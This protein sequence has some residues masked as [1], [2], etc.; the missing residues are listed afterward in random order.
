MIVG[1]LSIYLAVLIML[2]M[3]EELYFFFPGASL[4]ANAAGGG[5]K[6][7]PKLLY[8]NVIIDGR[9]A[10]IARAGFI[11]GS[12]YV[13]GFVL[14]ELHLIADSSDALKRNRGRRGLTS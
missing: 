13:P 7:Q 6:L 14:D 11:E 3:K 9:I 1:L 12:I 5:L 8:T 4:A 2:S 10:D